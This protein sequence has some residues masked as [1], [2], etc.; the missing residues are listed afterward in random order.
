ML[1]LNLSRCEIDCVR[2][3][4]LI[5]AIELNEQL[6]LVFFCHNQA[7]DASYIQR[8]QGRSRPVARMRTD[9]M[10][11]RLSESCTPQ[12]TNGA[13][14][15]ESLLLNADQ[16]ANVYISYGRRPNVIGNLRCCATTSLA[17][18]RQLIARYLHLNDSSYRMIA[19]D[20]TRA[21]PRHEEDK[22]HVLLDCG[23]NLQL[24]P[25]TWLNLRD[26]G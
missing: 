16:S 14:A 19:H 7:D 18:M 3:N 2:A 26:E 11:S 10:L 4:A 9:D 17:E 20:G 23:H 24:R 15:D 13:H 21:F 8:V 22:R 6:D 1:E 12:F 25:S 5:S